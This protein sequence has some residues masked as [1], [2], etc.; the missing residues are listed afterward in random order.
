MFV[1]WCWLHRCALLHSPHGA[2]HRAQFDEDIDN[3]FRPEGL[4]RLSDTTI[5]GVVYLQDEGSVFDSGTATHSLVLHRRRPV[6]GAWVFGAGT[7]QWAFGLDANH[8]SPASVPPHLANP[9][10]T[11]VGTDLAA[12]DLAMQQSTINLLGLMGAQPATL[13][14]SLV[15]GE[16]CTD[17]TPP[18][19]SLASVGMDE[20]TAALPPGLAGR[21][22]E[23]VTSVDMKE[24]AAPA[25]IIAGHAADQLGVVASVQVSIDA[26]STWHLADPLTQAFGA[27]QCRISP[28]GVDG[29]A[30]VANVMSAAAL[31]RS[32]EYPRLDCSGARDIR[33]RVYD[34]CGNAATSCFLAY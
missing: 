15:P 16:A 27:W 32:S 4:V 20:E 6:D 3:G 29:A 19:A 34:D 21:A 5:D 14:A 31:S 11:R 23:S 25:L 13:M 33:V 12:P 28:K 24:T 18:T 30:K 2:T 22:T 10:S 1:Y 7:C 9:Y 17:V 8:D 26:G